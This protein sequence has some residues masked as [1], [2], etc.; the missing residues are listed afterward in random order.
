MTA[1]INNNL[2]GLLGSK[3]LKISQVARDTGISRTTLTNLYYGR[4]EAIS[5]E[6]LDKLCQYLQCDI[7]D[8][9]SYKGGA[10]NGENAHN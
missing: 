10:I 1:G 6:V 9:I 3:R 8:I 5:Y 2:S 7:K 4:G